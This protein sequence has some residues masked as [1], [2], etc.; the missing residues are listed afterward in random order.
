MHRTR[1]LQ[2]IQSNALPAELSPQR[3]NE[4]LNIKVGYISFLARLT[5]KEV[6]VNNEYHALRKY[7]FMVFF[8]LARD[9]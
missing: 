4:R 3:G 8:M 5:L 9:H 7:R 2:I 6:E 1:Y